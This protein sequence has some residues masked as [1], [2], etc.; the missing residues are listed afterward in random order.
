MQSKH[1]KGK[2]ESLKMGLYRPSNDE[3]GGKRL[4]NRVVHKTLG[5]A[6]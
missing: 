6:R 3:Q 2:N 1:W 5:L 4:S